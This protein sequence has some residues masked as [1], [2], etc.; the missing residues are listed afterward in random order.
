MLVTMPRL[1]GGSCVRGMRVMV[2]AA[3]LLA[4]L[5]TTL[6]ATAQPAS[7]PGSSP[8]PAP[9]S[10]AAER[11]RADAERAEAERRERE[12]AEQERAELEAREQERKA[13]LSARLDAARTDLAAS[14]ARL[15]TGL[16]NANKATGDLVVARLDLLDARERAGETA[17]ALRR[18][19]RELRAATS[20]LESASAA[21]AAEAAA[22]YKAGSTTQTPPM[23]AMEAVVRSRSPQEFAE[24]VGYLNAMLRNRVGQRVEAEDDVERWTAARRA[25]ERARE[26]ALAAEKRAEQ[27]L[28]DAE[29][30]AP[31]AQERLERALS[32]HAARSGA[33]IRH[34]AAERAAAEAADVPEVTADT[35][36]LAQELT[37]VA[38]DSAAFAERLR[39]G[40][41]R[42]ADGRDGVTPW[43]DFRCPV[44]GPTQFVND[45][46][47]PRSGSRSHEGTD[48]FAERG[49]PVVAMAG[50]VVERISRFDVGLGGLTV[51]YEVDGHRVYNAHLDTVA[52]GLD[53]GDVLEPG[54]LIGTI[55]T[56]GNARGTP[57]HNHV[58]MYRPDGAP[59]NP[60]PILRRACR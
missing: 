48:V 43:R 37:T 9:V 8:A 26:R 27:E 54:Q 36:E 13:Q 23:V 2:M 10:P 31:G 25:A 46:G 14:E 11:E 60:Y 4:L 1:A 18:A 12:R 29:A 35:V 56:T 7:P 45:W 52:D 47:F 53:V 28:A 58:G 17:Q 44:D 20:E 5:A 34:A 57:P 39:A 42:I 15:V 59:V 22:A 30:D 38:R 24:G 32:E 50:A 6:P 19:E 55:G 3:T 40:Y 21:L 51:T 49:T 33:L 41:E 16:A